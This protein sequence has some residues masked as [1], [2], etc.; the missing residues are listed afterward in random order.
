MPSWF[1]VV[2][3]HSSADDFLRRTNSSE[4]PKT[5]LSDEEMVA[6]MSAITLAGHE[7]TAHVLTWILYE[8]AR[9]PEAQETLR[10]E[11]SQKRGEINARGEKDFEMEDLESMEYLQAIIKVTH[12]SLQ[13]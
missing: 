7:T 5:Q 11:I 10:R 12:S 4:N 6:Q 1:Q 8:L 9:H 3:C 13:T 2:I